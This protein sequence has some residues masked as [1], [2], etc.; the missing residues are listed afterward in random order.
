M[1]HGVAATFRHVVPHQLPRDFPPT[2]TPYFSILNFSQDTP[3]FV[4]PSTM[5]LTNAVYSPLSLP[6]RDAL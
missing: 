6:Y 3:F 4:L 5:M 2:V 1:H